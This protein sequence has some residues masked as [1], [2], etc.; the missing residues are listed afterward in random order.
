MMSLLLRALCVALFAAR[1]A[2]AH[3]TLPADAAGSAARYRVTLQTAD[4][5][6]PPAQHWVFIR[7]ANRIVIVRPRFDEVWS[8]DTQGQI[9]LERVFHDARKVVEYT[10]GE[11]RTLGRYPAWDSLGRVFDPA[12][13]H[14]LQRQGTT[15]IDGQRAQRYVGT[16]HG[17]Q[18]ELAWLPEEGW[19]LRL[20]RRAGKARVV[21]QLDGLAK[22]ELPAGWPPLRPDTGY[23]RYDAA[24]YG[25]MEKDPFMMSAQALD[26]GHHGHA[27]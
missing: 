9:T 13:L 27:H 20:I 5:K 22:G 2:F 14:A 12:E 19:P 16:L 25:D 7:E 17:E 4:G 1:A 6:R 3:E 26:G 23:A 18:V 8:R 10:P 21:Y 11:L 15:T 24:D